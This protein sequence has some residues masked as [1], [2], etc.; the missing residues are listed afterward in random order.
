ML[1]ER[2]DRGGGRDSGARAAA[3][4][5][6]SLYSAALAVTAPFWALCRCWLRDLGAALQ[7]YAKCGQ[8]LGEG[9]QRIVLLSHP[10]YHPPVLYVIT[11]T[12]TFGY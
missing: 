5:G 4:C 2:E 8:G 11:A 9:A 3:V 6:L 1:I 12:S 7:L 10:P